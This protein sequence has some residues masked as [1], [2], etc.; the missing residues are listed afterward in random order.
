M[1]ESSPEK[2]CLWYGL[3]HGDDGTEDEGLDYVSCEHCGAAEKSAEH[4]V[5]ECPKFQELRHT[6]APLLKDI[7]WKL[8]PETIRRCNPCAM[9]PAGLKP[10]WNGADSLQSGLQ[11]SPKEQHVFGIDDPGPKTA[12]F[13]FSCGCLGD[14]RTWRLSLLKTH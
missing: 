3:E 4:L 12:S 9:R 2:S 5:F 1:K 11:L 14:L 10:Y 6:T 7:R 13:F 8:I